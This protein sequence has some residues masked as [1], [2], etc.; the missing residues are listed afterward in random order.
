[1]SWWQWFCDALFPARCIIC[2]REGAW[3]CEIHG[4]FPDAPADESRVE[5]LE[6]IWAAT[7]YYS[8]TTRKA[9]EFFKFRGFA[10]L[11]DEFGKIMIERIPTEVLKNAVVVP[12]PLHWTRRWWR[13]FNQAEKITQALVRQ[14]NGVKMSL[15]LKRIRRTKQQAKLTKKERQQNLKKAFCWIGESVPEHII[16]VDDVVASGET[17]DAAAASLREVGVKKVT[18]IVFARGGKS[19]ENLYNEN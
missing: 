16:L 14:S 17:L 2:K 9:I 3:F 13:G 12:I 1:M 4:K 6:K 7:A 15:K 10:S 11:A 18:G 19:C 8:P 5:N